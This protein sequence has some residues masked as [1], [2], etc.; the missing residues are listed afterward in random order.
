MMLRNL[1]EISP[2]RHREHGVFRNL[3]TKI[4]LRYQKKIF[5]IF[6]CELCVSVVHTSFCVR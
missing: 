2:Q 5:R 1:G 4:E 6:L 3:K